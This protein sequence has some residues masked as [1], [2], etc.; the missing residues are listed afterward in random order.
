[1]DIADLPVAASA[2]EWYSE[3]AA[4]IGM[5]AVASGIA[6]HLGLPPHITGS[7]AVTDL[8]LHG[9][10]DIV[11]AAFMVEPDPVKAADLIDARISAK[12][13]ALGLSR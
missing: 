7:K 1:V 12:R 9:L 6:T 13:K 10:E 11:G 3:K 4:A 2:P 5:Y 8:A